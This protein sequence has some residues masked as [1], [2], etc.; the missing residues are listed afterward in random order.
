MNENVK[1]TCDLILENRNAMEKQMFWEMD[2][3]TYALMAGL[4]ATA[5]NVHADPEKYKECKKI[6]QK[7]AGVFSEMRGLAGAVV[8][9]K[10]MMADDPEKYVKGVTEVYHK[11]RDIHK[12]TASPYMVMAAM[13]I[14]E[15]N[16]VEGADEAIERLE[17]L[18]KELKDKHP[19]LIND[20]DR[21]YLSMIATSKMN[22]AEVTQRIEAAYDMCNKLSIDKDAVYSMA[23]ML[24]FS[25]KSAE[26]KFEFVEGI[27]S[28]LDANHTPISK[29]QGLVL[30]GVLSL[31]DMPKEELVQDIS[32]AS[33]YL[34][35]KSGFKWF[36]E[37]QRMRTVYAALAVFLT[38]AKD[39]SALGSNISSNIA[40]NIAEEIVLLIVVITAMTTATIAASN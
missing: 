13:N 6:L 4:L 14:Y 38:Y 23:Q 33:E 1:N 11:L 19:M 21:G 26:N 31:L 3:N 9:T 15:N 32:D 10:M 8:V 28:G 30:L 29:G 7:N 2:A 27:L 34:K 37:S 12:L 20:T 18:Y 25:D 22:L 24:A 5:R 16:G 35:G 17:A 39:K 40:M 36:D